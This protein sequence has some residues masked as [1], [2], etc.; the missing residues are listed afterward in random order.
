MMHPKP[1]SELRCNP[2]RIPAIVQLA[3]KKLTQKAEVVKS[4]AKNRERPTHLS[5]LDVHPKEL[6]FENFQVNK[7]YKKCVQVTNSGLKTVRYE[8]IQSPAGSE[9]KFDLISKTSTLIPGMSA[10]IQVYLQARNV[11]DKFE[12]LNIKVENGEALSI[13]LRARRD[14]PILTFTGRDVSFFAEKQVIDVGRS[15]VGSNNLLDLCLV[16]QGGAARYFVLTRERYKDVL[17]TDSGDFQ[18]NQ[19]SLEDFKIKPLY[20]DMKR[21]SRC[22]LSIEFCPKHFG[23]CTDEVLFLCDNGATNPVT[24]KGYGVEFAKSH[25]DFEHVAS[26]GAMLN[27]TMDKDDASCE[28]YYDMGRVSGEAEKAVFTVRNICTARN[29]IPYEWKVEHIRSNQRMSIPYENVSVTPSRGEFGRESSLLFQVLCK[30]PNDDIY[31]KAGF[32]TRLFCTLPRGALREEDFHLKSQQ[33]SGN[34]EEENNEI[35][36]SDFRSTPSSIM[37]SNTDMVSVCVG[38]IEFTLDKDVSISFNPDSIEFQVPLVVNHEMRQCVLVR[39]ECSRILTC[40]WSGKCDPQILRVRI[41][42]TDFIL[43]PYEEQIAQIRLKPISPEPFEIDVVCLVAQNPLYKPK[44]KI[45]GTVA[46]RERKVLDDLVNTDCVK[47]WMMEKLKENL[48]NTDPCLDQLLSRI[49]TI[50]QTPFSD[51][52]KT[53]EECGRN[54]TEKQLLETLCRNTRCL[55][56]HANMGRLINDFTRI[57]QEM[58]YETNLK[59]C[60]IDIKSSEDCIQQKLGLADFSLL[61]VSLQPPVFNIGYLS[62]KVKSALAVTLVNHTKCSWTYFWGQPEDLD[63]ETLEITIDKKRGILKP[64]QRE[65][66]SVSFQPL[67]K[68]LLERLFIPCHIDGL[69]DIGITIKF[70]VENFLVNIIWETHDRTK[71]TFQW[72]DDD[73]VTEKIKWCGIDVLYMNTQPMPPESISSIHDSPP[74]EEADLPTSRSYSVVSLR[75]FHLNT[76]RDFKKDD[77]SLKVENTPQP[78]QECISK[79]SMG[80]FDRLLYPQYEGTFSKSL[81]FNDV[82]Y[83]T[84]TKQTLTIVNPTRYPCKIKIRV[85][86]FLPR[87]KENKDKYVIP[88]RREYS[89]KWEALLD[90]RKGLLILVEDEVD[91]YE[92]TNETLDVEVCVYAQAWGLYMDTLTIEFESLPPFHIPVSVSIRHPPVY[93]TPSCC[94]SML[95]PIYEFA[96][97]SLNTRANFTLIPMKNTSGLPLKI[98]WYIGNEDDGQSEEVSKMASDLIYFEDFN[99][100]PLPEQSNVFYM[101]ERTRLLKLKAVEGKQMMTVHFNT[102]LLG[103]N[104]D[105]TFYNSYMFGYVG[106][107]RGASGAECLGVH[108]E[109]RRISSQVYATVGTTKLQMKS[110]TPQDCLFRFQENRILSSQIVHKEKSF[111]VENQGNIST[112]CKAQVEEPFSIVEMSTDEF[113]TLDSATPVLLQPNQTILIT[114]RCSMTPGIIDTLDNNPIAKEPNTDSLKTFN[115]HE[116][117]VCRRNLVVC[118]NQNQTV[119]LELTAQIQPPIIKLSTEKL[120]F[121]TVYV[122]DT[123]VKFLS[124]QIINGHTKDIFIPETNSQSP[125]SF[126]MERDANNIILLRVTF[127]PQESKSY[128]EVFQFTGYKFGKTL[129]VSGCGG[130][131]QKYRL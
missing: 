5:R 113:H 77:L 22:K 23:L 129:Q 48:Q 106:V 90:T 122:G 44:I 26:K 45:K 96:P 59:N 100:P 52:M 97:I 50:L 47:N 94:S 76:Q 31:K 93:F 118:Y 42:P 115:D 7:V 67:K 124:I 73:L 81:H 24:L 25:M 98:F 51:R 105:A 128:T 57:F 88:I 39:N 37:P 114:I 14:P 18:T 38:S 29:N 33:S 112:A 34:A 16:H 84:P 10:R 78:E 41:L 92:I 66:I 131:D 61:F 1:Y 107:H 55:P 119:S 21:E 15:L 30:I 58:S 32:V 72:P 127:T 108:R 80:Q 89:T 60:I 116:S 49:R 99:K 43:G 17:E 126:T 68:L 130:E 63:E 95:P 46:S 62:P 109:I 74:S 123:G 86:H 3:K 82:Q 91:E 4:K 104:E 11:N 71:T 65:V 75:N 102:K 64:E 83:K 36:D 111:E 19:I 69:K 103:T 20:F 53:V 27:V 70:R 12:I 110:Y 2:Q 9:F 117:L 121:R 125:F 54:D 79:A 6:S 56:K 8:V 101:E 35:N 13:V 28:W 40:R 85:G 87:V 120:H